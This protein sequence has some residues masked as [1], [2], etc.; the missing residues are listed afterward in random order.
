MNPSG[1][2]HELRFR[3]QAACVVEV[4]GGLRTYTVGERAVLDG[5]GVEE[6][7]RSGRGQILTP[8][9]NR[10]SGGAYTFDDEEYQLPLTEPGAGNAIH[11]LVR[12]AQWQLVDRDPDRVT[13]E[14]HLF[15]QPGYPFAQHLQVEYRLGE[16]GLVVST[17][18]TNVGD[19][20]CPFGL[21]FHPY[22]RGAP[23]V[24]DLNLHVP[25]RAPADFS[26]PKRIGDTVLDTTFSDLERGSDGLV[27]V[28]VDGTVVW[29]DPAFRHLQLFTGDTLPDVARRGLAVEPMTC[30]P[31]AFRTGEDLIRL[32]PNQR[33]TASW[34]IQPP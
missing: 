2:Q 23:K 19:R 22:L 24:D 29:A 25:A 20:P 15:P 18:V 1:A 27:R 13:L 7:C 21:G 33:F 4:G 5:Y 3:D 17:L 14:H 6:M 31:N 28:N 11:G 30:P 16:Q 32:E 34:G 10:I 9:P 26:R 12:W 8:W